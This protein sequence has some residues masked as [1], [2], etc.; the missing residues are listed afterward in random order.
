MTQKPLEVQKAWESTKDNLLKNI[1]KAIDEGRD[2]DPE[3]LEIMKELVQTVKI[4]VSMK[5]Y[6]GDK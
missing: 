3:V 6:F 2:I 4:K 5:D 1:D